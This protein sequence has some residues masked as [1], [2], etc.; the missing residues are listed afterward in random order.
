VLERIAIFLTVLSL[1]GFGFAQA[2]GPS[3]ADEMLTVHVADGVDGMVARFYELKASGADSLDFNLIPLLNAGA[4]VFTGGERQAGIG[5]IEAARAI[6]PDSVAVHSV[7]GQ[8]YWYAEDRENCVASFRRTLDLDADHK[9]ANQFWDLLFFVPEDF[10]VPQLMRTEHLRVRPLTADDVDLDYAAVMSSIEHLQGVFGPGGDWPT[11]ELTY[12]ED[13][14]ALK[15]HE[16]EHAQRSAFTY[17]VLSPDEAECLGCVYLLPVHDE[18][19]DAQIYLWVT[20]AA[21]DRSLDNE[22]YE[23]IKEWVERDW[24]FASVAYPGRSIDWDEW[25]QLVG[26]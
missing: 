19:F 11:A 10:D 21:F 22:L 1:V 5:L 6:F 20:E 15:N 17:T 18:R 13:L 3:V 8:L 7:L 25:E 14:R 9:T 26:E 4:G 24:P 23:G 16:K 12:E 2:E